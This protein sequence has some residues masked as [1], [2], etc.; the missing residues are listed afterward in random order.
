MLSALDLQ[1][2]VGEEAP[3]DLVLS[4]AP[5]VSGFEIRVTTNDPGVAYIDH[6]ILPNYEPI[7]FV[8]PVPNGFL[9][10]V[11]DVEGNGVLDGD[12]SPDLVATLCAVLLSPGGTEIAVLLTAMDDH[13]GFPITAAV[14]PGTVTVQSGSGGG[15][16]NVCTP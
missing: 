7:F 5:G 11:A 9:I 12:V 6:V 15:G 10:A 14:E 16:S 1:G 13:S 2:F 4:N 8:W 3:V